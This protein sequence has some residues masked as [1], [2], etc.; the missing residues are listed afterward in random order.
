MEKR[1]ADWDFIAP[2]IIEPSCATASCH[3]ALTARAGVVLE[4]RDTAYTT[5]TAR[6]F[7]I[8]RDP[9]ESEI[10]TLMRAQGS[11]RMP[12]DFPLPEADIQLIESWI[13]AG[14]PQHG[15]STP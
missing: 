4:P 6:Q 7:V 1:P 5:L 10:I 11:R 15:G 8:P 9:E 13:A 12:P 3:S 14:A 2:A